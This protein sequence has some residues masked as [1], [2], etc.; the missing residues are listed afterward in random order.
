MTG[1]RTLAFHF[2]LTE[3]PLKKKLFQLSTHG[4]RKGII[5]GLTARQ[6]FVLSPVPEFGSLNAEAFQVGQQMVARADPPGRHVGICG[7]E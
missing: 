5:S 7:L 3:E 6:G 1:W 4:L 2:Q